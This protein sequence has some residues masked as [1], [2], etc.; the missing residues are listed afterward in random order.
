MKTIHIGDVL[1]N[2]K[3]YASGLDQARELI[4][5]VDAYVSQQSTFDRQARTGLERSTLEVSRAVYLNY[6]RSQVM[7]WDKTELRALK[8]IFESV[9]AK[10]DELALQLPDKVYLIKTTG[11]EEG[12]AAYT[13]LENVI[14]LPANMVASIVAS[15]GYG[16]PLHPGPSKTY[17]ENI[18]IHEFFHLLS[19]NNPDYRRSLYQL[20]NYSMMDNNVELPDTPGPSGHPMSE[21][22]IT[23]PDTPFLNVY[24]KMQSPKDA[25]ILQNMMPVLLASSPYD[26]G[27]FFSKL[28]WWF[29]VVD[30]A[31]D[32]N[33][34][35]VLDGAGQPI[36]YQ[37]E[38]MLEQYY[39]L[40]GRNFTNEIFHPDE[41]LAQSFVLTMIQPNSWLL[42]SIRKELIH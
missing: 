42:A 4:T 12:Y 14:V 33:W 7:A 9:K 11:Q 6:V 5:T 28:G 31:S 8:A 2:T 32:G 20:V 1:T 18:I 41:I 27:S 35:P 30:Q 19:K 10:F 36:L 23:N 34:K 37:G 3:V 15:G 29:M 24:I 39:R 26:G 25:S 38:D 16:D 21:M 40:V 13:R 17:L 22:K